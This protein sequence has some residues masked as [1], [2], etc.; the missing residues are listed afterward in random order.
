M[1]DDAS[2]EGLHFALQLLPS[3]TRGSGLLVTSYFIKESDKEPMFRKMLAA[4]D[5]TGVLVRPDGPSASVVVCQCGDLDDVGAV[6]LFEW[7]GYELK[8]DSDPDVA[9]LK[10]M[11]EQEIKVCRLR[12]QHL[13]SVQSFILFMNDICRCNLSVFQAMGCRPS[14][15]RYFAEWSNRHM[16]KSGIKVTLSVPNPGKPPQRVAAADAASK[17]AARDALFKWRIVGLSKV[18]KNPGEDNLCPAYDGNQAAAAINLQEMQTEEPREVVVLAKKVLGMMTLCPAKNTPKEL[19]FYKVSSSYSAMREAVSVLEQHA[20]LDVDGDQL[21][22]HQLMALAVRAELEAEAPGSCAGARDLQALLTVRYGTEKDF[23]VDAGEYVAMRVMGDAAEYAVAEVVKAIGVADEALQRWACGMYLRLSIVQV[24]VA[25]DAE[26]CARLLAAAKGSLQRMQGMSC[27]G[28]REL[29]WRLQLYLAAV[30]NIKGDYDEA[31][32]ML[33][34]VESDFADCENAE[35]M[36]HTLEYIGTTLGSKGEHD[37]ALEYDTRA[38]D[39]RMK[40][41]G[42]QHP[43]VATSLANIGLTLYSKGEHDKALEYHTRARDIEMERLGPRHPDVATSLGNIGLALNSKGEHDKA[44]EYHTLALDIYMERLG[45]Q[46]PHVATS[47]SNIGGALLSKGEHDKA[48]EYHSRARDIYME[49]LGPRHPEVANVLNSIGGALFSKGEHDKALEY[50]TRARDIYMERLGPG[51][52]QVATSLNNIGSA[53]DS[54][55]EHDKAVEYYTRARDIYKERLGPRHPDVALSLSNIGG[56]LLSKGEHDKA[57]EYFSCALDIRMERLGPRHPDVAKIFVHIS[58]ALLSKGEHDKALEYLSCALDIRM[59]R[60][61]PRHPDVATI[62]DHISNLLIRKGEHDK[63]LE[64]LSCALDIR[65]ERLGPRH[66]DVATI[67]YQIGNL[68]IRKG[69]HDKAL[70][71]LSCALDIRM[72]RLGPRHPDVATSLGYIGNLLIRKGEH[73]KALEYLTRVPNSWHPPQHCCNIARSL[74][75]P[76]SLPPSASCGRLH[77]QHTPHVGDKP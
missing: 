24:A 16:T 31:L 38:L 15:V 64:Y 63:A 69:E 62:F 22:M 70:E 46:H 61:G 77:P 25:S 2:Q 47:L 72:E 65:M 56:A 26:S 7:C 9:L 54:K 14:A 60:L 48:L 49:R 45:P 21:G 18:L 8:P 55:G 76:Q 59:E 20:L 30:P 58:N 1:L 34:R 3:S 10:K 27:A 43:D 12:P 29:D 50:H 57:L 28:V 44:L 17:A 5:E 39:I 33:Q 53:L 52:P 37:K 74:S 42:P 36:G 67:F 68:L 41:L 19:F 6:Q 23:D 11:V 51:H 32:S 35:L 73:D 71:Y 40:R 4:T 75:C 13:D 66:P